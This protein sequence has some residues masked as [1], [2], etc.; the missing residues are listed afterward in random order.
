MEDLE[1]IERVAEPTEL[2]SPIVVA[3]IP[4]GSVRLWLDSTDLNKAI[5]RQHLSIPS[6]ELLFGRISKDRYF[7]SLDATS[8]F[9]QIPLSEKLSY[10]CTMAILFGRNRFR[11][12][13]FEILSSPEVLF[14]LTMLELFGGLEKL[15]IYFD[16]FLIRGETRKQLEERL[17][18]FLYRCRQV[19][20]RLNQ[21]KCRF[22]RRFPG[23]VM[24][25]CKGG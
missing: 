25:L 6:A 24:E 1:A 17:R 14:Q 22:F 16:D 8:G 5:Q 18:S 7:A 10:L 20:L 3:S 2:V 4:D 11:R 19:N 21:T 12:L 15:K 13:P 9:F 23:L